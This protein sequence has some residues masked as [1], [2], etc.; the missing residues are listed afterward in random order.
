MRSSSYHD[1]IPLHTIISSYHIMSSQHRAVSSYHH[2]IISSHDIMT[3]NH[4]SS[5]H[6][7]ITSS[8]HHIPSESRLGYIWKTLGTNLKRI[9]YT[10]ATHGR[11]SLRYKENAETSILHRKNCFVGWPNCIASDFNRFGY[12]RRFLK[13]PSVMTPYVLY[14]TYARRQRGG[15]APSGKAT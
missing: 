11:G 12:R 5:Y 6:P 1:I 7:S 14:N 3:V 9:W 4:I 2:I 10:S 15:H 8:Y 13:L